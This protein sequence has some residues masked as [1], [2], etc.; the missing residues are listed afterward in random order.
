MALL[1]KIPLGGVAPSIKISILPEA[2]EGN[3]GP[4][5][6]TDP[7][8]PRLVPAASVCTGEPMTDDEGQ[9][10]DIYCGKNVIVAE[11]FEAGRR[12]SKVAACE[13]GVLVCSPTRPLRSAPAH[14][15]WFWTLKDYQAWSVAPA[16]SL[17]WA[18]EFAR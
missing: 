14:R 7:A 12:H 15:L 3:R 1:Q 4:F 9:K 18:F 2:D 16:C 10:E 8:P 17:Q 6:E 5:A 11:P 13:V